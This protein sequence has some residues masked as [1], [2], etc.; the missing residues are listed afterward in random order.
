[1]HANFVFRITY[2][3]HTY[4]GAKLFENVTFAV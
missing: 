1:M 4:A 3:I 2:H